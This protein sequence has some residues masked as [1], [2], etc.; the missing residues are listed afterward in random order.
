MTANLRGATETSNNYVFY[1]ILGI[2]QAEADVGQ[3]GHQVDLPLLGIRVDPVQYDVP[4]A[5]F[6]L[7]VQLVVLDDPY[8]LVR[9]EF[10]QLVAFVRDRHE[11]PGDVSVRVVPQ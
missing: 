7:D 5:L 10:H 2:H 6:P 1:E 8:E 4:N 9:R 11:L 3:Q